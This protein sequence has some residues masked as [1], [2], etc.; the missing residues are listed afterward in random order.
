[1]PLNGNLDNQGLS[2][3]TQTS[4]TAKYKT[5]G[6]IGQGLDL[7]SRLAFNCSVL[8]GCK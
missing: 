6:K 7:S 8:A 4:G 2:V 1:L 5:S 3:V